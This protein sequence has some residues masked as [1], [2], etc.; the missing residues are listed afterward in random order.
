MW[1][2]SSPKGLWENG[3]ISGGPGGLCQASGTWL[4][5]D[6][7]EERPVL[8]GDIRKVHEVMCKINYQKCRASG[9]ANLSFVN[10]GSSLNYI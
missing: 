1:S 6:P 2:L 3:M 5:K 9:H 4:W 10:W 8:V 7:L